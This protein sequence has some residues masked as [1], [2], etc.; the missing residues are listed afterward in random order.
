MRIILKSQN[1]F[2]VITQ[3]DEVQGEGKNFLKIYQISFHLFNFFV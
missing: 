2:W 3:I 1:Y